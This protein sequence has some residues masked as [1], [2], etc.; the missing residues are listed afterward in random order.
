LSYQDVEMR[1]F[2][3]EKS[4]PRKI[5]IAWFKQRS[6]SYALKGITIREDNRAYD[7]MSTFR[8]EDARWLTMVLGAEADVVLS[9]NKRD[10][11]TPDGYPEWALK[12]RQ[13]A[14]GEAAA[15]DS[16]RAGAAVLRYFLCRMIE[17]CDARNVSNGL[18]HLTDEANAALLATDT[19]TYY[20]LDEART[21]L[22]RGG[23][24]P[25]KRNNGR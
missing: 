4:M 1:D 19:G 5:S 25:G 16:E 18:Q 12:T 9:G 17:A 8:D 23:Q 24:K 6:G 15:L 22:A 13:E 11:R 20:T 7:S 2:R 14:N 3:E 21:I 10:E